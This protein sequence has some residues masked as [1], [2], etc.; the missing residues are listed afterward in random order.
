MD[1][2]RRAARNSSAVWITGASSGLGEALALHYAAAGRALILWGRDA[3]RLEA[4]AAR[5]RALG[6]KVRTRVFD[7]TDTGALLPAITA[8]DDTLEVDL[9]IFA[10][11]L[12]DIQKP[13][14]LA[15]APEAVLALG[16][17]NFAAPSMLATAMAARMAARGG[18]QIIL[19][20]SAASFHAL[21]F[22]AG[23]AGSKAGLLRFGQALR[24]GMARHQV[25]VTLISPGFIDTPMSRRLTS[26]KPFMLTAQAAAARIAQAAEANR[27]HVILPWPFALLR[28]LDAVL[29]EPCKNFILRRLRAE[30]RP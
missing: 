8:D 7:L 28:A 25:G 24:L 19:I 14:A 20:G 16:L 21:P 13:G 27:G 12:G 1:E 10:A 23:Y 4:V 3:A 18:G 9:A 11:G 5:C 22:A 26:A 30:Q 29:P 15:E 17:V 2:A 6:A